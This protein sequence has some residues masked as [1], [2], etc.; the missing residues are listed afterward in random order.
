M[1]EAVNH[2]L[3]DI[4]SG[5]TQWKINSA[6]PDVQ[7]QIFDWYLKPMVSYYFIKRANEPLHIQLG[8]LEPMVTVVNH[9][10][11][12]PGESRE[13]TATFAANDAGK[14]KPTLEVGGWN[15]ETDFDCADLAVSPKE[16]KASEPFTVSANRAGLMS[17]HLVAQSRKTLDVASL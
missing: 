11:L 15:V 9:F 7:W 13:V 17:N 5:F 8:L 4:T 14:D 12:L 1:F 10:G 3:W 16:I 6:W 2:R